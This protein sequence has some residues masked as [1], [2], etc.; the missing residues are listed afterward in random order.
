MIEIVDYKDSWPEEFRIIAA[1]LRQGLGPL[2]L[3]IDHIGS[4][5][6]RGLAAKDVID[7]QITVAAHDQPL[8]DALTPL[9][10]THRPE[11]S[12]DHRPAQAT[13]PEEDWTKWL[14]DPPPGQRLTHTHVRL[15]GRANQR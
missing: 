13:G 8:K 11:Y 14:F 5:S 10:Y 12:R 6:V 2:A 3:R 7:L 4:T 9:G 1:R 15:G